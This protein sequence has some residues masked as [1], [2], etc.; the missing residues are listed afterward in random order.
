LVPLTTIEFEIIVLG[1]LGRQLVGVDRRG[2]ADLHRQRIGVVPGV[3]DH[4][5]SAAVS[6]VEIRLLGAAAHDNNPWFRE[7]SSGLEVRKLGTDR[8][9]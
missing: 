5:D 6:C 7:S 2:V 8:C 1:V 4:S 9:V 3:V